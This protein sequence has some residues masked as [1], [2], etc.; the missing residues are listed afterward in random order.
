MFASPWYVQFAL[1]YFVLADSASQGLLLQLEVFEANPIF[2]EFWVPYSEHAAPAAAQA[3]R[4]L[5]SLTSRHVRLFAVEDAI[6]SELADTP[7]DIALTRDLLV[8]ALWDRKSL[9]SP[10]A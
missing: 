8:F 10:F 7:L 9:L 1:S 4:R 5:Y 6:A 2:E 3:Y